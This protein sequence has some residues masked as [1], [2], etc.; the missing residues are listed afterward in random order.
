MAYITGEQANTGQYI[1]S[2]YIIDDAQQL[3]QTDV[4][5]E[6]FKRMLT[7]LY[8][9]INNQNIAL[10]GKEY[11]NYSLEEVLNSQL[12]FNPNSTDPNDQRSVFRKVINFGSLPNTAT[13]SV[14]HGITFDANSNIT[15]IYGASTDPAGLAYIPLPYASP[16]LA[17]NIE[18]RVD[19][20]NVTIV[21]G[22]N[23]A[24]FTRTVVI[25]EYVKN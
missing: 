23:R 13:T 15:R 19:I 8:E 24:S 4:K 20:T 2:T 16:I 12:F 10:N 25:I 1:P 3:A 9:F 17:N 11:A 5:S 21:T 7:R 22:I 18:L 6:E 14:A